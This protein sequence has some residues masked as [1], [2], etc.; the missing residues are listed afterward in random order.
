[1]P[2][3]RTDS[4]KFNL[5]KTLI[6]YGTTHGCSKKCAI[7][8]SRHFRKLFRSPDV[9]LA[10]LKETTDVRVAEYDIVIIG[11]SIRLGKMNKAVSKFCRKNME[12]LSQKKIGLFLCCM[13]EPDKAKDY[14][15]GAFPTELIDSADAKGYFG[16]ELIF[17]NMAAIEKSLLKTVVPFEK[18]VSLIDEEE[19]KTFAQKLHQ[20]VKTR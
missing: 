20:A 19:I 12:K 3:E 7:Q 18:S 17:E 10:D 13:S 4:N 5:M 14:M 9:R 16:G 8:L 2:L 1:M 6:L 11:G 15:T